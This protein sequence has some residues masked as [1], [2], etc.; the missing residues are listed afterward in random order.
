MMRKTKVLFRLRSLEMCGVV[1]VLI[2]I[3]QHLPQEKLDITL[4]VNLHQGELR[5]EIP[6][7]IKII[8]ITKGKEDFNKNPLIYK[9]QLAMRL[10]KLNLLN[11]FPALMKFYYKENYDVEIRSEEH[12][13]ELQSRENLVCRLLLE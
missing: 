3:L 12:T 5:N 2:D 13:S 6:S 10:L 11:K 4:M 1:K 9:F 8:K 7:D